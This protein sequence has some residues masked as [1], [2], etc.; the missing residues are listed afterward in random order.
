MSLVYMNGVKGFQPKWR[1]LKWKKK[2][3]T[4]D[5]N[6]Y[7]YL[8]TTL[9]YSHRIIVTIYLSTR[10]SLKYSQGRLL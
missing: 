4:G 10:S 7:K 2:P 6:Y 8:P 5:K 3:L 1:T 9:F